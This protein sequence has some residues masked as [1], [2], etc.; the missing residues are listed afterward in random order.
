MASRR[1]VLVEVVDRCR[2]RSDRRFVEKVVKTTLAFVQRPGLKVSVLLTD[3]AEIARLHGEFLGDPSGTDVLSFPMDDGVDV[4][5]SVERA[6]REAKARG[7]TIKAELALYLVHGLLHACGYDDGDDGDR[8][9]MRKAEQEV[10][11]RLD[12]RVA[13]IE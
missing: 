3:D 10:L 5:V 13:P 4:V 1:A 9:R 6:R 2:P 11:Q 12:L 8:A 7:H